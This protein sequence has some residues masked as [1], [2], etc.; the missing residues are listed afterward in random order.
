LAKRNS[1][2]P[3]G[4]FVVL[5]GPDGSGK[6]TVSE[7][8]ALEL[9]E[10]FAGVWR[11]HWRPGLLPKLSRPKAAPVAHGEERVGPSPPESSKYT[12][13]ISLVRFIYYLL[14][15]VFGYWFVIFPRRGR[16]MLVIGERY[17]PDVI[18]H[19]E[20]YGF[21]VPRWLLRMAGKCV[22]SPDL[23]VLLKDDPEVIYARK[24]ELL[25]ESI[26]SQLAQYEEELLHWPHSSV[27][28][29]SNG[30]GAVV[31]EIRRNIFRNSGPDSEN[32]SGAVAD[33]RWT[34]F[35]RRGTVKVWMSKR[36]QFANALNLYQPFSWRGRLCKWGVV[37]MPK[38]MAIRFFEERPSEAETSELTSLRTAICVALNDSHL[39]ASFSV[40]A[41]G[42]HQKLTAQVGRQGATIAYVKIGCGPKIKA[43]LERECAGL[44]EAME[45]KLDGVILPKVLR[46]C[47][48]DDR[49]FLYLSAPDVPGT[50]R[51]IAPDQNDAHFLGT[52]IDQTRQVASFTTLAHRLDYD[53]LVMRLRSVDP[54]AATSVAHAVESAA[55]MLESEGVVTG[56]SHGDYAPWNTLM[57]GGVS[58]YVY[59][60][61]YSVSGAPILNDVFHRVFMPARLVEGLSTHTAMKKLLGLYRCPIMGPVIQKTGISEDKVSAYLLLYVLGLYAREFEGQ[62]SVS[63]YLKECMSELLVRLHHPAHRRRILVSAYA[64]EPDQGSEPGVGWHWVQQI[65]KANETWVITRKNNRQSIESAIRSEPN[66]NLH[67]AYVDLPRFLTFWK[68]KQRGVRM[69]Y[70]LWQFAALKEAMRLRRGVD[71]DL[72]H[73]VTFVNDWLF[74]FLVFLP[75]PFVWGPIGSHPKSPH[76]LTSCWTALLAD[77]MRYYFQA[78]VRFIDPLFWMTAARARL[79]I[80]IDETVGQRFPLSFLG[81]DKFLSHPAIGVEGLFEHSGEE[82]RT[83]D[84]I[85]VLSMGRLL[86]IKAFHLT[87]MAFAKLASNKRQ[88]R[89]VIVGKGPE[90]SSLQ[91]LAKRLGVLDRIIF[92]DWLP[93]DQ[94]LAEMR[95]ADLFVFPSFEGGGMVVLEAMATGLPVVCL[96]YG[97]PGAMVTSSCGIKVPVADKVTTVANLCAGISRLIS[98]PATRRRMGESGRKHVQE[99]FLWARKSALVETLYDLVD[100]RGE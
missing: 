51:S 72:A 90:R 25:P 37:A 99:H 50:S 28:E 61:E 77:R 68:R 3:R 19:P 59:D 47:A 22:P 57:L 98:E 78:F 5:V 94:A 33:E 49:H 76:S 31:Q 9:Q 26:A 35:P 100:R 69:Y 71:F 24:P 88:A 86:P 67:F 87:V 43:L 1:N 39:T 4:V 11:F 38:W 64:C 27:I 82:K 93:R 44:A 97:G 92:I 96:D 30:A 42:K 16:C 17:Y 40:G 81:R 73:H 21:S 6:S 65:A 83:L 2:R 34:A 45:A 63:S 80:G 12:G 55:G 14:D 91:D 10:S 53:S 18:V 32:D 84:S 46:F 54:S 62:G 60:W 56:L 58:L 13:V 52:L 8:L 89:L 29:T 70:Y 75:V 85:R 23:I 95:N 48:N 36:D 41:P 20:R 74:T 66:S 79:I 7:L 15:F